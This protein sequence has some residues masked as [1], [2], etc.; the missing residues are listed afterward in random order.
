V[1]L[2]HRPRYDDWT[3]PKGKCTAGEEDLDCALREVEEETG[4]Q[5]DP[6][7]EL[8]STSYRDS[9]GRPKTVRYWAMKPLSGSFAPGDEVDGT[10]W[11]PLREAARM[12]SYAR[13]RDVLDS[14][15]RA[16]D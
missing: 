3:L 6:G 14:L 13:D 16:L 5:C 9:K 12:V 1:L 7:A 11:L 8:A 15:E 4:L 10:R 2:V